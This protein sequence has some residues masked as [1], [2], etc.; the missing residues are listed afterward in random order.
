MVANLKN[1]EPVKKVWV[2]FMVTEG[3]YKLLTETSRVLNTTVND[4]ACS[5][6][7]EKLINFCKFLDSRAKEDFTIANN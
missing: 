3:E 1:N 2:E 7:R 6:V 5:I 4:F